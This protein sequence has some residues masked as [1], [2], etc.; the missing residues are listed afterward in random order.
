[1]G[2]RD[3]GMLGSI[4]WAITFFSLQA[5]LQKEKSAEVELP[6]VSAQQQQPASTSSDMAGFVDDDIIE[7]GKKAE[8]AKFEREFYSS[9]KLV[10]PSVVDPVKLEAALAL[11]TA[12]YFNERRTVGSCTSATPRLL[13]S[14]LPIATFS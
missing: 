10:N 6:A 4:T 9:I 12:S 13:K 2:N 5:N 8:R 11:Y 14:V 7:K 1:M 3:S